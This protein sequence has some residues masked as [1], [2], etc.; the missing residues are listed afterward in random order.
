MKLDAQISPDTPLVAVPE[1][2][3][4]AEQAGFDCLW[5][6]ETQHNPFLP[7]VL[8]AEHTQHLKF[9]TAIAVSFARSP[10]VM[11]QTAWDLAELSRGRFILGLGTQVRAHITRRFG[12]PWPESVVGKLREQLAVMRAFWSSW[13]HGTSLAFEGKYYT[14]DLT[15]PFFTPS[16]HGY[17]EIP[18]YLAG[19]NPG[20]ARLAGETAQGFHTHPFHSADYLRRAILPP[21]EAGAARAGR[22]RQD[23]QVVVHAFVATNPA[24]EAMVRQQIAFYA[25]T[26]SYRPVLAHHGWEELG[27]QLSSLAR[28]GE[29]GRM[30]AMVPDDMVQACATFAPPD[31]LAAALQ[32][33]YARIAD[34]INLYLPYQPGQ[35]DQFWKQLCRAFNQ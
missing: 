33:R 25:S 17:H 16:P 22:T 4:S 14:I 28:A 5:A 9:G 20:L 7:G 6:A 27:V 18:I 13:Q 19:V 3:R 24:E 12:M 23:V 2:A 34:R 15:S 26:P 21:I 11:A 29:W 35:R 1:I 32:D 8:T 10:A 30:S 31:E